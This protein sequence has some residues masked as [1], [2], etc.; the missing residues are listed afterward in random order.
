MIS[1]QDACKKQNLPTK[2]GRPRS[3]VIFIALHLQLAL[4]GSG[5]ILPKLWPQ[6]LEGRGLQMGV[7]MGS[8]QSPQLWL[9]L[10]SENLFPELC[11]SLLPS[12]LHPFLV[13][14]SNGPSPPPFL[15]FPKV[16]FSVAEMLADTGG[17]SFQ[18]FS[19]WRG[20]L[21]GAALE[22][23]GAKVRLVV[24]S[25]ERK[26]ENVLKLCLKVEFWSW[27]T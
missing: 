4:P 7:W 2:I 26:E 13:P 20:L 18:S 25:F 17:G 19:W 23:R 5:P 15:F 21:S 11:F 6:S 10:W 16:S 8:L 24:P 9:S 27:A 22:W 12:W 14:P 3:I 1:Y